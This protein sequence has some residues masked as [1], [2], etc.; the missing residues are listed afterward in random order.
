MMETRGQSFQP[1]IIRGTTSYSGRQLSC[2]VSR[3]VDEDSL[4]LV[5][6][7]GAEHSPSLV[8]F[9]CLAGSCP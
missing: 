1:L 3:K 8:L 2:L 9:G 7:G 5:G 6:K 4:L